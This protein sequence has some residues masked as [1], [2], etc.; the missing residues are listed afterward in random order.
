MRPYRS[1]VGAVFETA[2][3]P[4]ARSTVSR[5]GD[6]VREAQLE[7]VSD[8]LSEHGSDVASFVTMHLFWTLYLG[9]V[10]FWSGDD[11]RNQEDTLAV[12]DQ[13][14][15]VFAAS[16]ASAPSPEGVTPDPADAGEDAG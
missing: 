8:L 13:S 3:S 5:E 6:A 14:I 9:V 10:A 7:V 16:L 11:S 12:L 2:M 4:F 1:F 15:H